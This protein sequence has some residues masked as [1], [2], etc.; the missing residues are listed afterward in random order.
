VPAEFALVTAG[1]SIRLVLRGTPWW[2]EQDLSWMLAESER[3]EQVCFA[4]EKVLDDFQDTIAHEFTEPW[5]AVT[6][7]PM[8]NP[9][10]QILEGAVIAG[11]GDPEDPYV[12]LQPI[13]LEDLV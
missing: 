9:F 4:V 5:P 2:S 6:P 10:A 3:D 13:R 1:E 7:A 12:R 11:Y 8:P